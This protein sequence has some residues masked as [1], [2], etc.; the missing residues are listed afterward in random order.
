MHSIR[1][2]RPPPPC[3]KSGDVPPLTL[4]GYQPSKS[5]SEA[6]TSHEKL[7][8]SVCGDVSLKKA[9]GPAPSIATPNVTPHQSPTYQ[10]PFLNTNPIATLLPSCS[11]CR[12]LTG[13]L[14]TDCKVGACRHNE[15]RVPL[16]ELSNQLCPRGRMV[17]GTASTASITRTLRPNP[18]LAALPPGAQRGMKSPASLLHLHHCHTCINTAPA[19][20][21]TCIITSSASLPHLH[22]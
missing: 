19:H 4:R 15:A 7:V 20:C 22:H 10:L 17:Y 6:L 18:G 12:K 3:T 14:L 2:T 11:T 21:H 16:S 1:I 13:D 8:A 5:H 9:A